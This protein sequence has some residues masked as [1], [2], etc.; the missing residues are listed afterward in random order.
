[1]KKY[2]LLLAVLLSTSS[3]FAQEFSPIDKSPMDAAFFPADAA[4]R[5]F[6]KGVSEPKVRVLYSRP[7]LKDRNLFRTT[8][9]RKDG[10]TQYG[11]PWRLGANESTELLL[12][13]DAL[14]GD[15]LVKA[16]RYSIVVT[17]TETE[18][19]FHINSENDG[20]GNYSHK[21]ELDVVTVSVPVKIVK[22]RVEQLSIT[23]YSPN[24]DNTVH[25]KT[26]WGKYR[27]ELPIVLK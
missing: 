13:Q 9:D 27:T 2:I 16:G 22:D 8:E 3:L 11:K 14:I 15:T 23:M 12:M 19:T 7:S 18:W 21:P 10:I 17:P 6:K 24:N 1:M 4:K 5:A 25:L 20:W 26:G